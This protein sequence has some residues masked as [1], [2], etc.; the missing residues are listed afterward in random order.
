MTSRGARIFFILTSIIALSASAARAQVT[1]IEQNDP[2]IVYSGT[3]WT[4]GSMPTPAALP[5]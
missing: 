1:R 5:R 2:S 4:N 3:W